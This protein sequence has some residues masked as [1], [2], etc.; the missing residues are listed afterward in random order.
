MTCKNDFVVGQEGSIVEYTTDV[1]L[2]SSYTDLAKFQNNVVNKV[3]TTKVAWIT[4]F[5]NRV[6]K[7]T[8]FDPT[9]YHTLGPRVELGNLT[10]VE[11]S[12]FIIDV[13]YDEDRL[14][15]ILINNLPP[16]EGAV[17]PDGQPPYT[18]NEDVQDVLTNFD[19]H[20]NDNIA[21]AVTG[22]FCHAFGNIFAQLA[23]L[24][25]LASEGVSKISELE[26]GVTTLLQNYDTMT[27]Q[28][29]DELAKSIDAEVGIH[30]QRL[31]DI[32]NMPATL[33]KRG[34]ELANRVADGLTEE[35]L[36][37]T[38]ADFESTIAKMAGQ[39]ED[40]TP[41]ALSF[42]LFRLCQMT[43]SLQNFMRYPL[44]SLTT[45]VESAVDVDKIL[46][47]EYEKEWLATRASGGIAVNREEAIALRAAAYQAQSGGVS[48]DSRFG[49]ST[50]STQSVVPNVSNDF[51]LRATTFKV[52]KSGGRFTSVSNEFFTL[53]ERAMNV[54]IDFNQYD[55]FEETCAWTSVTDETWV[56][57]AL[58]SQRLGAKLFINS[59]YRTPEKN[60]SLSDAATHSFHM[61]G[62]ALDVSKS[63]HNTNDIIKHGN[64]VGFG[65]IGYYNTF[66]HVDSRKTLGMWITGNPSD[67]EKRNMHIHKFPEAYGYFK[68][69]YKAT[70]VVAATETEWNS[71]T[72]KLLLEEG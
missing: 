22:D 18:F 61:R 67:E 12:T 13:G 11:I 7:S 33:I 70:P 8:A 9:E 25:T 20:L 4:N 49:G 54:G 72:I 60:A 40:L 53:S 26:N 6:V 15:T 34:R 27:K 24:Y 55:M 43:T 28:M 58:L 41:E 2:L 44:D 50:S 68:D 5:M 62:M 14:I 1:N 69:T 37:D 64:I 39:F 21:G 57:A 71:E 59:A 45:F 31:Q 47:N 66:I 19:N 46:N 16:L 23:G 29:I 30:L 51:I 65:G 42:L 38:K 56:K 3:D 48:Q 35:S 10:S 17:I 36:D 32:T 52:V 63:G